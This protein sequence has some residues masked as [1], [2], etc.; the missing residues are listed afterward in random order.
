MLLNHLEDKLRALVAFRATLEVLKDN[1]STDE[2][3]TSVYEDIIQQYLDDFLETIDFHISDIREEF[4]DL[5]ETGEEDND[6]VINI[7]D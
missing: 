7:E 4:I 5:S 6:Y 3:Y 2:S 1:V